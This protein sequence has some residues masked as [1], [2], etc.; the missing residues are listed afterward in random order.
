M[1]RRMSRRAPVVALALTAPLI[2][3]SAGHGSD[4]ASAEAQG[5]E[6]A[7]CGVAPAAERRELEQLF[8]RLAAHDALGTPNVVVLN[9]QGYG[10]GRRADLQLERIQLEALQLEAELRRARGGSDG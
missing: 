1:R 9:A 3:S 2:L 4:P 6:A 7:V 5:A 10:Y 8:D